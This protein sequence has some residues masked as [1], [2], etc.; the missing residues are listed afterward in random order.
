MGGA[1]VKYFV[2]IGAHTV[3]VEVEGNRVV[4]GGEMLDA[5]LAAVPATPLYHLLLGGQS[6]TVAAQPL[7]RVG[8]WALGVAGERVEVEVVDERTRQIQMLTGV[9]SA[10]GGGGAVRAP[11]PGLVVRV[12]VSEGQRVEAGAA[13][14]VVEAMKMENELRAPRAGV[15]RT[16][17]VESGQA[18]EKGA[19]LVTL[20]SPEG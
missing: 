5:H 13:L 2:T 9:H 1:A 18:V 12:E 7:E 16:V 4:V 11:M 8:R 10:A 20:A 17:H 14:V 15:V 3:E 6:W 19:A